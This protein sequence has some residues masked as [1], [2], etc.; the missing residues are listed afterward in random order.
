[1]LDNLFIQLRLD[2][3]KRNNYIAVEGSTIGLRDCT[4]DNF[5]NKIYENERD[6]TQQFGRFFCPNKLDQTQLL[7]G[8]HEAGFPHKRI[9]FDIQYCD[10]WNHGGR[11]AKK[12]ESN[13]DIREFLNKLQFTVYY[14][15]PIAN[16]YNIHKLGE[17]YQDNG[18]LIQKHPVVLMRR[19]GVDVFKENM[20][21]FQ[22]FRFQLNEI[23]LY[24]SLFGLLPTK[25]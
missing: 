4:E 3:E 5:V 18:E 15:K 12:C 11:V 6:L 9:V 25:E 7:S 2:F 17:P 20:V 8:A 19:A 22:Y 10:K 16:L 1:M 24:D 21:N 14:N 13:E 23:N